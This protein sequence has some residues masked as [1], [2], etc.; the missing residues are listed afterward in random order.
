MHR[1]YAAQIHIV[2]DAGSSGIGVPLV[3][4]A[5]QAPGEARRRHRL[6]DD[7]HNMHVL[8]LALRQPYTVAGARR[9]MLLAL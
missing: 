3:T 2:P 9:T 4:S 6:A 5:P 8:G 7:C 1:F